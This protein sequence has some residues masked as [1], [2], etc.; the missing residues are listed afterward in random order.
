MVK[1][2]LK[3]GS[4]EI[5]VEDYLGVKVGLCRRCGWDER[6]ELDLDESGR[7]S[8]KAKGNFSVYKT[9]GSRRSKK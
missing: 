6:D 3:C 4:E 7:V 8:Q 1:K 5:K 9:G 2:C